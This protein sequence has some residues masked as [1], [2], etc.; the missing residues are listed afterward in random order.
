MLYSNLAYSEHILD[1]EKVGTKTS[2]DL[3]KDYAI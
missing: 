1:L 2:L 3:F